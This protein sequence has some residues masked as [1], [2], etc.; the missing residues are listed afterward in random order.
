[1]V[2]CTRK[3]FKLK[4]ESHKHIRARSLKNYS[5]ESFVDTLSNTDWSEVFISNDVNVAWEKFKCLFLNVI[6]NV[7]PLKWIRI[8]QRTEDWMTADILNDIEERDRLLGKYN[9]NKSKKEYFKAYCKLRNKIQRDIKQEKS[10][11]IMENVKENKN[12]PSK[13]WKI[14]KSLG[15][16]NENKSG[17]NIVLNKN[18]ELS[19]DSKSNANYMNDFFTNVASD[20]V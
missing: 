9:R 20:L 17:S 13:L 19:F 18:G 7:A 5:P 4:F 14:L 10:D 11:C 8:K 6:D 2:Y 3:K 16:R 15:F 1:M 12:N